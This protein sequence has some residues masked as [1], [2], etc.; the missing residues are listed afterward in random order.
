MIAIARGDKI[1]NSR[2]EMLGCKI[3][4]VN[5]LSRKD[6]LFCNSNS[7]WRSLRLPHSY[8]RHSKTFEEGLILTFCR[9]CRIPWNVRPLGNVIL[10]KVKFNPISMTPPHYT[11]FK[12]NQKRTKK[13][14]QNVLWYENKANRLKD[15]GELTKYLGSQY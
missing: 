15:Y 11:K 2:V 5:V 8:R 3:K 13:G 12:E 4:N 14:K 7:K 9:S 1:R 10:G 6:C